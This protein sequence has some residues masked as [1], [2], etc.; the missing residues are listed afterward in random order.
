MRYVFGYECQ[1]QWH[2]FSVNDL[3]FNTRCFKRWIDKDQVIFA[4]S[5]KHQSMPETAVASVVL[6]RKRSSASELSSESP[7]KRSFIVNDESTD[8]ED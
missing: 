4:E 8:E 2:K 7:M 3:K 5:E 1:R 6:T